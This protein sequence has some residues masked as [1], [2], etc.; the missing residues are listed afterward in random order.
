MTLD[1]WKAQYKQAFINAKL[2]DKQAQQCVDAADFPD[3]MDGY[4]DD[5]R[6]AALEE[7]SYW[8]DGAKGG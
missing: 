6:G 8:N 7:M 1:E 3:V 2:T 5:P 4:E